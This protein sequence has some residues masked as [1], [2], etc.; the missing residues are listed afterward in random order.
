M[1]ELQKQF[2]IP[3]LAILINRRRN[4]TVCAL[5]PNNTHVSVYTINPTAKPASISNEVCRVANTLPARQITHIHPAARANTLPDIDRLASG[6]FPLYPP[7]DLTL[8]N[9]IT[10]HSASM[11]QASHQHESAAT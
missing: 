5:A 1:I 6:I 7:L 3:A 11:D 10:T 8:S 9:P 4:N 2:H